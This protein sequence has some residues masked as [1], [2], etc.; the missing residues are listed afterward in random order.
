MNDISKSKLLMNKDLLNI[1]IKSSFFEEINAC[2]TDII[3]DLSS[4]Q[5][6][7]S[8]QVNNIVELI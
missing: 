5:I 3:N 6:E 2:R 4:L 8:K 1:G 7:N